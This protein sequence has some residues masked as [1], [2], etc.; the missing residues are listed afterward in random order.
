MTDCTSDSIRFLASPWIWQCMRAQLCMSTWK[1]FL[2]RKMRPEAHE[3]T[4][5]ASVGRGG[6][7]VDVQGGRSGAGRLRAQHLRLEQLRLLVRL[8]ALLVAGPLRTRS[9]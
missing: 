5:E 4:T 3:H 9:T 1:L 7:H 6:T 2:Y 8:V